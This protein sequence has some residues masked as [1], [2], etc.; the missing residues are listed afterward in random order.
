MAPLQ[1]LPKSISSRIQT[2]IQKYP[3]LEMLF[4]DIAAHIESNPPQSSGQASALASKKR[5]LESAASA[6][7]NEVHDSIAD[8]SFSIPQRKKLKLE[9]GHAIRGSSASG[10]TECGIQCDNVDYCIVLPVPEK[11]QPQYSFCVL[12]KQGEDQI[13]FT[14]PG[15][16]IKPESIK[17][18]SPVGLEDTYREVT[19]RMLNRRLKKEVIEPDK[20]FASQVAQ[21]HRKGEKAVHVK[22][23]RGSKD[24]K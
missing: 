22:A 4:R 24:G 9:L 11:A 8:V 2:T 19:I 20:E 15:T 7:E 10:E 17:S 14:V 1:S 23:F 13:L 3:E 5:K 12:P 16:T 6:P 18:E 21:A